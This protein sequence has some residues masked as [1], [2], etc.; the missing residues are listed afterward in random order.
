MKKAIHTRLI[1]YAFALSAF[2]NLCLVLSEFAGLE[3]DKYPWFIR[4]TNAIA[5]PPGVFAKALLEPRQ[6]TVHAFALAASESMLFSFIF[7]AFILWLLFESLNVWR[8]H[9]NSAK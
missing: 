6:H 8:L 3:R 2:I 1:V 5:A 4:V 7:Y 9:K